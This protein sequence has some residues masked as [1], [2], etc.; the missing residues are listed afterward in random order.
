MLVI[1]AVMGVA[2]PA[3]APKAQDTVRASERAGERLRALLRE[4]EALASQQSKLLNELRGLELDRQNKSAEL[5]RV[6]GELVDTERRL[7]ESAS[8]KD[9]L[10]RTAEAEAPEIAARLVQ[11]YKMGRAGYWRLLLDVD[12]F[13]SVGRAYR[14]AAALNRI[15]RDRVAAHQRTLDALA[16]ELKDLEARRTRLT[17]LRA[18]AVRARTALDRSVAAQNAMIDAIDARRDLNAQ[19]SSELLAA[20]QR[21]QASL[22]QAGSNGPPVSLPL[23]AFQGA[24]PW[25]ARGSLASRFGRQDNSRFGTS[26]VRNGVEISV[27]EGQPVSAVHEGT[28]AFA[29]QFTGY[30]TLVIIE[31]GDRAFSLYGH[32]AAVH[33]SRGERVE[34]GERIGVS[35]RNPG[36]N[37]A[38]YFELRVDGRPVDPLQWLQKGTP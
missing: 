4:A 7:A 22:S 35:G 27:A 37:P 6:E 18:E 30:G 38:L 9:A 19:M 15:D 1:A 33:V 20:Q 5:A 17:T 2:V 28:V 32:L 16:R 13:R 26:V 11:L 24:L 29:D 21:L 36:G 25:P 31:H 12:D 8:R 3:Q 34:A 14:T 10:Q 23:E